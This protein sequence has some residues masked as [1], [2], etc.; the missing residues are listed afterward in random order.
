MFPKGWHPADLGRYPDG[1]T[2]SFT[3]GYTRTAVGG[4][5]YYYIDFGLSTCAQDLTTGT[6][7]QVRAPELSATVAYD[8]YKLDVYGLGQ[9]YRELFTRVRSCFRL[10]EFSQC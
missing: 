9:T 3:A 7:G 2:M 1:R 10:M 5:R 4:V 6:L 8:P